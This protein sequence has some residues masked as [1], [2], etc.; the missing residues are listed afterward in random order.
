MEGVDLDTGS[1]MTVDLERQ[2]IDRARRPGGAVRDR[3]GDAARLL[4]GLDEI[5]LTLQHEDDDHGVRDGARD[6]V[7]PP[8]ARSPG[9]SGDGMTRVACCPATGSGRRWWPRRC[10]CSTRS[11]IE[12][13]EHPFGGNAILDAGDAAPRRDARRLPRRLTPCSSAPSGCPSSRASRC[14]RSRGCSDSARS[15]ASTRTSARH[16]RRASTC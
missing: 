13:S 1:E 4:N 3:R 5:G 7:E 11:G 8:S 10:G 9:S 2:V 15:S 12:H 16:A 6:R 14:A